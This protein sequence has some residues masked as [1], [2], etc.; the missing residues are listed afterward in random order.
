M[1][2]NETIKETLARTFE[3]NTPVGRAIARERE[4]EN[5]EWAVNGGSKKSGNAASTSTRAGQG[6]S[7]YAA[8]N[9]RSTPSTGTTTA[10]GRAS[11]PSTSA[12]NGAMGN[13]RSPSSGS[14]TTAGGRTERKLSAAH[15][16]RLLERKLNPDLCEDLG[17]WSPDTS[18]LAFDYRVDGKLHNTKLRR[19]KGNMPW[20]EPGKDLALWNVDCLKVEPAPDEFVIITEGEPDGASFV[21][22]GFTRVVSLPNGAQS[23]DGGFKFLY[24]RNDELLPDLDKFQSFILATDGDRKGLACRDALA[25]RLGDER[26]KHLNYPADCKDGNDILRAHGVQALQDCVH[27]ARPMWTEEVC[28]FSD[29]PDPGPVERFR[30]GFTELDHHGL[31]IVLPC[32]MPVVGPYGSGKSV[33]VRQLAWNL[34]QLH[35]WRFLITSWEEKVKPRYQREFRRLQIGMPIPNWTPEEIEAADAEIERAAIVMRRAKR[36]TLDAPRLLANIE[37]AVKVYGVRTVVIDPV[38]SMSHRVPP[39]TNKTDYLGEFIENLK[40][41]ADDYGLL[42][43]V[44]IHPPKDS[45]AK[46]TKQGQVLTLNDGEGTSHWGNKADIGICMWRNFDGPTY[47][48]LDKT[49]DNETMGRPT[50]ALLDLDKGLGRFRVQRLGYDLLKAEQ[51][52]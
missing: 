25:V 26:C 48:H 35:G 7:M 37:F 18:T 15:R 52:E 1:R 16:Q 20:A 46:R 33:W 14:A 8:P 38:N 42:I 10:N 49:K 47:L 17:F 19:G 11:S 40:D 43:I 50:L 41:L 28:R 3:E 39:G 30:T 2:K 36:T 9:A 5:A 32:F 6:G 31:R 22:C 23:N 12:K 27:A 13:G 4:Q 51:Q 21:Q 34:W 24:G 44:V 29:I 45:V